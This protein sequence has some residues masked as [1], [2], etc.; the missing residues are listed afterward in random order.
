M[1]TA[2][3]SINDDLEGIFILLSA[4]IPSADRNSKYYIN[5]NPLDI[6]NAVTAFT[7]SILIRK[8]KIIFGGHPTISPLILSVSKNFIPYLESKEFPFI[9]IYQ[10]KFFKEISKFTEELLES[11]IGKIIW[12]EKKSNREESLSHMRKEMIKKNPLKAAVF[13]GGM[14]GIEEEYRLFNIYHSNHPK[15]LIGSTGGATRLISQEEI[16]VQQSWKKK[17]KYNSN[18]LIEK[19]NHS[20]QYNFLFK[21]IISDILSKKQDKSNSL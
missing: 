2:E 19:L 20:K 6:T 15:Y 13:I 18:S 16:N 9:K 11:G 5:T 21:L 4:S 14:E 3:F 10:S 1:N 8:G 7:R 17:L 12:T